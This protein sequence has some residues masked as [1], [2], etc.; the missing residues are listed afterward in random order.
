MSSLE[1][2]EGITWGGDDVKTE[3]ETGR[4][5]P[6]WH[7]RRERSPADT[8]LSDFQPPELRDNVSVILSHQM[9]DNL[10]SSLRKLTWAWPA[11]QILADGWPPHA[12]LWLHEGLTPLAQTLKRLPWPPVQSANL[13]LLTSACA[14]CPI[15]GSHHLQGTR[16]HHLPALAWDTLLSPT[17]PQGSGP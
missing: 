16:L 9:C 5:L 11:A 4:I 14:S 12:P 6:P 8:C 3:A 17:P 15:R 10:L 2:G 13:S 1:T 7:R